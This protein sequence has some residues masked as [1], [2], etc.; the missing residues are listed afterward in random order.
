MDEGRELFLHQLRQPVGLRHLTGAGA[1]VARRPA[2]HERTRGLS[3]VGPS[4]LGQVDPL[5]RLDPF[6][7]Q[8]VVR[9]GIA[10]PRLA[11]QRRLASLLVGI[12]RDS[13]E[14][15]DGPVFGAKRRVD[16]GKPKAPAELFAHQ[17]SR[18]LSLPDFRHFSTLAI[19]GMPTNLLDSPRPACGPMRT[20]M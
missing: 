11:C 17:M 18:R 5:A 14:A 1:V 12:P 9:V 3:G 6:D 10:G 4:R 19:V 16:V 8:V 13:F 15:R 2:D 7:R 20:L